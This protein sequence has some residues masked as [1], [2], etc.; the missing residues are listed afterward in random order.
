M[1]TEYDIAISQLHKKRQT[2][3]NFICPCHDDKEGSLSIHCGENGK[4]LINCFAG[5]SFNDIVK[6]L[7][8]R[9]DKTNDT[10][11]IINTYDYT[12][13]AGELQYQV[14]RYHPKS[15]KQRRP[16][17]NDWI[18]NLNGITPTLYHLPEVL[19]AIKDC[20]TI[21]IVEGE[22]DVDNLRKAGQVATTING[23]ASSK[24]PPSLI[25]QFLNATVAIIP[26]SDEPGRKYAQYVA[27]LLFGWCSS[28]KIVN[29]P[30][31]DVSDYLDSGKTIDNLLN[32]CH[33]TSEYIPSGIVTREE[34]NELRG[35]CIYTMRHLLWE[36]K[37]SN[38]ERTNTNYIYTSII[39]DEKSNG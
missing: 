16:D 17:G 12:N 24:W 15:F 31:K 25:P 1:S 9:P 2:D 4:V 3:K 21:W 14:V 30:L 10:P 29:L 8:L 23:G 36:K 38:K 26:D 20:K 34:F 37:E 39:E 32:I 28:L 6:K 35:L 13:E 7:D 18:W 19:Q 22:K 27:N 11:I 5:C 33:N